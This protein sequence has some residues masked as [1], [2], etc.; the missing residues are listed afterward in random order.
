MNSNTGDD[1]IESWAEWCGE[2]DG[3]F[4]EAISFS[5][6]LLVSGIQVMPVAVPTKSLTMRYYAERRRY[7]IRRGPL[8]GNYAR[9]NDRIE[10]TRTP[11]VAPAFLAAPPIIRTRRG[12]KQT[13]CDTSN[14]GGFIN[15]RYTRAV[16]SSRC[17]PPYDCGETE[18]Q[19]LSCSNFD[20]VPT[21]H[22]GRSPIP[23]DQDMFTEF[24]TSISDS[25][26]LIRGG[27]SYD[28]SA[29]I[30]QQTSDVELILIGVAP[31][32]GIISQISIS[33]TL[34]TRIKVVYTIDHFHAVGDPRT[35]DTL[36]W[37]IVLASLLILVSAVDLVFQVRQSG[38]NTLKMW[39]FF[40]FVVVPSGYMAYASRNIFTSDD[41][42]RKFVEMLA[43][44]GWSD[45]ELSWTDKSDRFFESL[46]LF[47]ELTTRASIQSVV[48]FFSSI[49]ILLRMITATASHP[50]SGVLVDTIFHA[51]DDVVNL[52]G[53][54][55]IL[56]VG[57]L[58]IATVQF[59]G[60]DES[61]GSIANGLSTMWEIFV[62]GVAQNFSWVEQ[63]ERIVFMV[64][65][66]LFIFF[67]AFNVFIAIIVEGYLKV[68]EKVADLKAESGLLADLVGSARAE[69]I[70]F[71]HRLPSKVVLV[72]AL[73]KCVRKHISPSDLHSLLP[74]HS[75]QKIR[76]VFDFYSPT[77]FPFLSPADNPY[78]GGHTTI[79]KAVDD[80]EHR[81]A[82]MLSAN[83]SNPIDRLADLRNRRRQ[84]MVQ[85]KKSIEVTQTAPEA[86]PSL[87][88]FGTGGPIVVEALATDSATKTAADPPARS[89][90]LR[91]APMTGVPSGDDAVQA[92]HGMPRLSRSPS[93][94]A[95]LGLKKVKRVKA[96]NSR[97]RTD[98]GTAW[99]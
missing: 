70:S 90:A 98:E 83:V 55:L 60:D 81:V 71:K 86:W 72:S 59:A 65:F 77:R 51:G 8:K 25:E 50:R 34:G 53:L 27:E 42:G 56:F 48:G 49:C 22:F 12:V 58:L 13:D 19:L 80:M 63:T 39:D 9:L 73:E 44:V 15:R 89:G 14:L 68:K 6:K 1:K 30:D 29:F 10:Y 64:L 74:D 67:L 21:Q 40:S 43:Q 75:Y 61:F 82:M 92:A 23:A 52:L 85:K 87:V 57:F 24:L 32:A 16:L 62:G 91:N 37:V 47:G 97:H 38:V 26:S 45:T 94:L 93:V 69:A 88:G 41:K 18:N 95:A 7:Q 2:P 4:V 54:I 35:L 28:T 5:H 36:R 66:A 17:Q 84:Q 46:D 99:A 78:E 33:A 11:F 31:Q 3:G 79:E 76:L 96:R 20:V